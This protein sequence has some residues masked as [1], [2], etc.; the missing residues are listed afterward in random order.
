[1]TLDFSSYRAS[2]FYDELFDAQCVP[3]P[4]AR[5]L[6]EHLS[7]LNAAELNQQRAAVDAAIMTMGI[8]F[9]VY[10]DGAN[11]DRAWPFDIIPRV[12]PNEEWRRIDAGSEAA[13]HC[14]EPVHR[15]SLQPAGHRQGRRLPGGG[16]RRA[17]EIFVPSAS[18]RRPVSGYGRT[19]AAPIWSATRRHHLRARGQSARAFGRFVHAREPHVDETGVPELFEVCEILPVDDYPARLL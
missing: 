1:M 4:W 19:S 11:I 14:A 16:R 17:P 10:S 7:G 12:M 13:A 9:T 2:G 6:I 8:T 5:M 15:R 3:R 18:A